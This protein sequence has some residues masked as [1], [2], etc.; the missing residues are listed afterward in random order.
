MQRALLQYRKKENYY[1]V[2][3]ALKKAGREDLIGF[4][5][6]CLIKP[7]KKD[8]IKNRKQNE[9]K[10]NIKNNNKKIRSVKSRKNVQK[11]KYTKRK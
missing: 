2:K 4:S 5:D 9:S 6:N 11:S 1:I 8:L 10:N 3:E 7:E